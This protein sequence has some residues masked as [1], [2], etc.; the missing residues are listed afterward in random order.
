MT[1]KMR[2]SLF[3]LLLITPQVFVTPVFAQTFTGS[4]NVVKQ[5][6]TVEPFNQLEIYGIFNVFLSQGETESVT[7][8]T[9][10]N[11][12]NVIQTESQNGK[13]TVKWKDGTTIK[14]SSK[15][16]IYIT[17]KKIDT[18][19]MQG[20][21]NIESSTMLNLENLSMGISGT[22]N[23]SL[24][25]NCSKLKASNSVVGDIIIKG[26]V[27]EASIENEGVGNLKAFDL[28]VQKLS[29]KNTGVGNVEVRAEEEII[30]DS[31]GIGNI[32]YKGDATVKE[33]KAT[34]IGKVQK[35]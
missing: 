6:R 11:L 21:G 22:V 1:S 33:I 23:T 17:L 30:I 34:G 14:Q 31:S 26:E 4:G 27:S 2:T 35:V 3:L 15:V 9:D 18:L 32:F 13:L 16:N 19:L 20:V 24:H 10:E 29:I 5:K 25:L 28:I 7:I 12:L 8:E